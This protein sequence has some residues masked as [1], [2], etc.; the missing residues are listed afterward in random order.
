[1]T[2]LGRICSDC[3]SGSIAGGDDLR[4]YGPLNANNSVVSKRRSELSQ[5]RTSST[6]TPQPQQER[7]TRGY[8]FASIALRA[9]GDALRLQFLKAQLDSLA[10]DA[11]ATDN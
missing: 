9:V 11:V 4:S 7:R 6:L 10:R 8:E 5:E 1:M 2:D 3:K